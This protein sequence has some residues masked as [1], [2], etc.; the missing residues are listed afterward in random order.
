MEQLTYQELKAERDLL[1]DRVCKLEEENLRLKKNLVKQILLGILFRHSSRN[2]LYKKKLTYSAIYSRDVRMFL[3]GDGL[4]VQLENQ[5]ISLCVAMNGMLI[6]V[7]KRSS[8][9]Q[10]VPIVS[11]H[12]LLMLTSLIICL[13]KMRKDE[14]LLEYMP[15]RQTTLVIFFVQT[16]TTR[17]VSMVIKKMYLHLL[18]YASNGVYPI[19]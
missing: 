1:R 6:F 8:N 17:I 3:P 16:L 19:K 11:S 12:L 15:L 9:V 4:A 18:R 5:D 2:S 10:S 7:T 14:M 13:G